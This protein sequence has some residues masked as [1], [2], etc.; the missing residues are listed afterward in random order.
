MCPGVKQGRAEGVGEDGVVPAKRV[1]NGCIAENGS[2]MS[3]WG[4]KVEG[5][6][7]DAQGEAKRWRKWGDGLFGRIHNVDVMLGEMVGGMKDGGV[8]RG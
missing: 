4:E 1:D 6:G 7:G 8:V 5:C 2:V 3:G